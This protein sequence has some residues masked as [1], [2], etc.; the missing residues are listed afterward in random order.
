[1][2]PVILEFLPL[3]F[4]KKQRKTGGGR[5][6][7]VVFLSFGVTFSQCYLYIEQLEQEGL[8]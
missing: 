8:I 5:G 7:N 1:M 6:G 3:V 4:P 2:N